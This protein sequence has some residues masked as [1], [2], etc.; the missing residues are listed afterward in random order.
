ME[1]VAVQAHKLFNSQTGKRSRDGK[2]VPPQDWAIR[3]HHGCSQSSL[4][5]MVTS[6][7]K[8]KIMIETASFMEMLL[9][10]DFLQVRNLMVDLL[11]IFAYTALFVKSLIPVKLSH[12]LQEHPKL[13]IIPPKRNCCFLH[14]MVKYISCPNSEARNAAG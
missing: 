3:V 14:Y 8:K 6:I 5:T 13:T 4:D 10:A 1:A 11:Q 2:A 12:A 9:L 7:Y